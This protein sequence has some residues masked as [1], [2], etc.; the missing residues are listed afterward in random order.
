L[1]LAA[2]VDG[3]YGNGTLAD[4]QRFYQPGDAVRIARHGGYWLENAS[5]GLFFMDLYVTATHSS[6]SSG[7]RLAKK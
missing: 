2:A 7:S 6:S 4:Y 1:F 5:Y 3:T